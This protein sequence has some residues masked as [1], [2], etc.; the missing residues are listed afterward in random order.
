MSFISMRENRIVVGQN[1]GQKAFTLQTV[2]A[3]DLGPA[4][5]TPVASASDFSLHAGVAVNK[6]DRCEASRERVPWGRRI[7]ATSSNGC[8]GTSVGPRWPNRACRSR[9]AAGFVTP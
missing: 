7:S 1:R 5:T 6:V 2:A 4:T 8:A 9:T 3:M